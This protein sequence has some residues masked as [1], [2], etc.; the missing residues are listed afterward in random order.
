MGSLSKPI[1]TGERG[2]RPRML[3]GIFTPVSCSKEVPSVFRIVKI[4]FCGVRIKP[5]LKAPTKPSAKP[6][7][8]CGT[9]IKTIRFTS[10]F[11]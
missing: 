9:Q 4:T 11:A 1:T 7:P 6:L 10:G 3:A 2:E 5:L 8:R